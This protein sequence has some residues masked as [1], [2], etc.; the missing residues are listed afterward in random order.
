MGK[1]IAISPCPLFPDLL[2]RRG[3]RGESVLDFFAPEALFKA[4][5]RFCFFRAE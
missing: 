3:K 2:P 1:E 4:L 5:Y